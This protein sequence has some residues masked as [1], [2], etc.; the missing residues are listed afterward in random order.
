MKLLLFS[1]MAAL[2]SLSPV[3]VELA[4]AIAEATKAF[5]PFHLLPPI[6]GEA[7]DDKKQA[8]LRINEWA[9]T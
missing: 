6:A 4:V 3:T 5:L 2:T 8:F 7:F 1:K 9:F